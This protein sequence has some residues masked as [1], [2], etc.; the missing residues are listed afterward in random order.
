MTEQRLA[1][2]DIDIKSIGVNNRRLQELWTM[3]CRTMMM[4]EAANG[5]LTVECSPPVAMVTKR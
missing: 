2:V 5:R 4:G 3:K 1:F